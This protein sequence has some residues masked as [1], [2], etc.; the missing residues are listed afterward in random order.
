MP[1]FDPV[2]DCWVKGEIKALYSSGSAELDTGGN[3]KLLSVSVSDLAHHITVEESAHRR[4]QVN[5]RI[6]LLDGAH[7]RSGMEGFVISVQDAEKHDVPGIAL[8]APEGY[9][10][11][12]LDMG[13]AGAWKP[14]VLGLIAGPEATTVPI[15]GE[16]PKNN[17]GRGSCFWC[18]APTRKIELVM[19]H[20]DICTSCGR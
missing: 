18:G 5:S 8:L 7:P 10:P 1:D 12:M 11:A 14:H 13:Y 4:F 2:F 9:V 20:G 17:D 16:E 6:V 3:T 19:S 15:I